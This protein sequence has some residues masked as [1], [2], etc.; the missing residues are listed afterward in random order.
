VS[1]P[2][3]IRRRRAQLH[4]SVRITVAG[5]AAFAL[6]H[7]FGLAQG[8]WA[9]L[10]AVIVMQASVG[11]S[12]KATLDRFGGSLGGAAW[13]VVVSLLITGRDPLSLALALA[14]A[15]APL[16][17]LAALKPT[18]RVAP[19]TAIILLLTPLGQTAG[20]LGS[21]FMRLQEIGLGSVVALAVALLV[22]PA[23]AHEAVVEAA[24]RAL[25]LMGDLADVVM[26]APD[27]RG[28]AQAVLSLHDRIRITTVQA[29]AAA[30]ESARE[31]ANFL[32]LAPDAEPLIR[33]LR[34]LRADLVVIG[35][36]TAQPLAPQVWAQLAPPTARA[37]DAVAA[38]LRASGAAIAVR[39]RPPSLEPVQ[40]ALA[41]HAAAVAGLRQ[42]GLTRD[43]PD[44]AVGRLFGLAF[45]LE[46][47]G[48]NLR[49]LSDRMDEMARPER[50]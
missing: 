38:F 33:T 9:V 24:G 10:T 50:R 32:T 25:V 11:G 12:L 16:S 44:E 28:E 19:V 7:L 1:V 6:A 21:A 20:P 49:D 34:R 37:A 35:R 46:Q 36:A 2:G 43:L 30:E 40:A 41:A 45:S 17:V 48:D 27:T 13:G 4:L 26:R 22:L 39:G 15:M 3:W 18:Y 23:R 42:T 31:R 14:V 8:Y 5:L 29:E 47:L